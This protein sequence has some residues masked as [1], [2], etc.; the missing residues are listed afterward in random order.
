MTRRRPAP[1]RRR[2]ADRSPPS[3][4]WVGGRLSPPFY[5]HDR[6]EPYRPDLVIWLELPEGLIVGQ[7]LVMPEDR[8]GALARGL[9]AP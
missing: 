6:E 7:S 1:D 3:R 2:V 4:E 8:E 9:P 5:I